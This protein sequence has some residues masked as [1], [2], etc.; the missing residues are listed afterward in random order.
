MAQTP[1]IRDAAPPVRGLGG[2]YRRTMR[3]A[4]WFTLQLWWLKRTRFLHR[5]DRRRARASALY[6]SQARRFVTFATD[7]GGLI[8]KLGQFLS[9]RIDV[10]PKEYIQVLG[11]LQDA[12]P[13]VPTPQIVAVVEREL[14]R[15]LAAAF[16]AFDDIPLAAA[17]L[18]QV[19]RARLVTGEDVAVKV[20]RPGVEDVI[21]T[22]V[23]SLRSIMR[24]LGRLTTIGRYLDVD[25][26]CDDFE[27]TFRDELDYEKEAR[28]AEVFA[29]NF[30]GS[31]KVVIPHIHEG[32][33][34]R[35]V[36]TM[37]FMGGV[38]VNEL[39]A[40]DA[41]GIDRKAV[42]VKLLELY[43]QM[44]LTDGFFHADPHPG[45]VFVRSDGVIQLLD[46]G[47]VGSI[48]D[49][50]RRDYRALIVG[51][52]G[53]DAGAVV[54]ALRRLGFLRRGADTRVLKQVLGP[55]MESMFDDV[56]AL[57]SGTPVLDQMMTGQAMPQ[58]TIDKETL[59][60]LREF[61]LSQPISLPGNTTFIG[62]A[63]ITVVSV[64]S[65][66]DPDVD[67]VGVAGPFLK[68]EASA[69]VADELW[70]SIQADLTGL[71]RTAL[72]TAKRLGPLTEK[73]DD[74]ELEVM[75]ADAEHR[76]LARMV[77]Q[78]ASRL[79]WTVV[80]AAVFLGGVLIGLLSSNLVPGIVLAVAGAVTMI[81]QGVT[82]RR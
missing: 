31:T 74:G 82:R 8:I 47:M 27:A 80:G 10:L 44:F 12:L 66:L 5:P 72:P 52:L 3:L 34:T 57:Y 67:I 63:F 22:D 78:Q 43:L 20:L 71:L 58:L 29:H 2:R 45:N 50:Q 14:D 55:L 24:M 15:P 64:C 75:L 23:R 79:V 39:E 21:D 30:A 59:E 38:K 42:A 4:I 16:T 7:M 1:V 18:G 61:I 17:S 19:H 68:R 48:P 73:L 76:R 28:N 37:E 26:F 32:F 13:P 46:F 51:V 9:V 62:K 36:L 25:E 77:S 53:K 81:A 40:L 65:A 35:R 11:A 41:G 70:P 33:S 69:T 60:R 49:A 6:T 54:D 56:S